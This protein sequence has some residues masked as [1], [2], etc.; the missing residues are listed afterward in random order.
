ME[1]ERPTTIRESIKKEGLVG[2]FKRWG[3]GIQKIPQEHLMLSEIYGYIGT[4]L[5]TIVAGVIFL[6]WPKMWPISLIMVFSVVITASQMIG[7]IQQYRA[8]KKFKQ[9]L[10]MNTSINLNELMGEQNGS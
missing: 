6:F 7:K 2:F 4:I 8:I 5:G 1:P 9:Q 10:Q 3:D